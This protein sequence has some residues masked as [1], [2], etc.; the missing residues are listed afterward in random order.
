LTHI[1]ERADFATDLF[2]FSNVSQDTL[3]YS[4]RKINEGSKAILM[5]LGTNGFISHP[6]RGRNCTTRP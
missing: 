2:V 6:L 4:T 1:L 3:D 5:G